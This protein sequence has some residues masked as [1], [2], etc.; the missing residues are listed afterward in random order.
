ML[1][2]PRFRCN[3]FYVVHR[4]GTISTPVGDCHKDLHISVQNVYSISLRILILFQYLF[5]IE[6]TPIG[7]RRNLSFIFSTGHR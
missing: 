7:Q 4:Q 3:L 6:Q 1:V 5:N 2:L